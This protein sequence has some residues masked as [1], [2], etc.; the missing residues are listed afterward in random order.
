MKSNPFACELFFENS[1]DSC[2][3]FQLVVLH[4]VPFSSINHRIF[5]CAL[6]DVVSPNI[7]KFPLINQS[8][9]VFAFGDITVR[10]KQCLPY[11]GGN[12]RPGEFCNNFSFLKHPFSYS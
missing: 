2:L 11:S 9:N 12:D 8:A 1:G 5:L 3:C 4:S 7:D 6:F 10:H